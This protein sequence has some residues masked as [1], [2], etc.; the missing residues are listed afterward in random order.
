V[1]FA[2]TVDTEADNQWAFGAPLRTENVR[3]WRAFQDTCDAYDVKPTY[4]ITSEIVADPAARDLLST[5]VGQGKAE[6]GAHLHAWTTPPFLDEPGYRENDPAHSY[7][8]ELPTDLIR[9]KLT[10]LTLEIESAFGTRPTSFRSGRF[11]FD[12]RCAE[13]LAELGY[14]VDSSVTPLTEWSAHRGLPEGNGG[15]DFRSHAATPFYIAGTGQ[16][17]L[18]EIPLTIVATYA[19]LRHST[20][21][22]HAYQSFPIRPLRNRILKHWLH[23]QPIHLRPTPE[24]S[25]W[26]LGAAWNESRRMDGGAAVMMVH[27]SELMPNGSPF[28]RTEQSIGDLHEELAAF[29]DYAR[30]T[31]ARPLTLTEAA[32]E[33]IAAR[34]MPVRAL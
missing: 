7:L 11:G 25:V 32:R 12:Q 3:Y 20:R 28:R 1:I 14:I 31:G 6:V 34:Q 27:S 24:F 23:P 4:L 18:L 19:P 21:L 9:A 26:D 22:L 16:P 13:V 10:H 5:W 2:M 8:S 33:L 30:T 15:P 17:G 29:F